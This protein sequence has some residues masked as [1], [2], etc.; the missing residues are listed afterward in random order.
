MTQEELRALAGQ[1]LRKVSCHSGIP[2]NLRSCLG[3]ADGSVSLI[4]NSGFQSWQG[5]GGPQWLVP[6]AELKRGLWSHEG[7]NIG[8]LWGGRNVV[9]IFSFLL[10]CT[11]WFLF[12][13]SPHTTFVIKMFFKCSQQN[14]MFGFFMGNNNKWKDSEL[15]TPLDFFPSPLLS[16][17][18]RCSWWNLWKFR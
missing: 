9:F 17:R 15:K 10:V 16:R 4:S 18:N 3:S 5:R 11:L 12:L 1:S 2:D 8:C 7:A 14:S 6:G 13:A